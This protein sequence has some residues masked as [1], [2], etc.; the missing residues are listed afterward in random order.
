[1]LENLEDISAVISLRKRV[2]LS[3]SSQEDLKKLDAFYEILE[4]NIQELPT[5]SKDFLSVQKLF[6]LTRAPSETMNLNLERVFQIKVRICETCVWV[7]DTLE[8]E[9]RRRLSLQAV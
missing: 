6:N 5:C 2:K 1:M 7:S 3:P 4:T 8:T 9:G